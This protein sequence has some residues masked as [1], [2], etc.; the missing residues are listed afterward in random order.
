MK[1]IFWNLNNYSKD[2]D[3]CKPV[4]V[5]DAFEID[6]NQIPKR[7]KTDSFNN[8]IKLAKHL[9]SKKNLIT[10]IGFNI[11]AHRLTGSG[12]YASTSLAYF[13]ISDGTAT[14][15]LS[16]TAASF[17]A[18][19]TT[20]TKQVESVEA[21]DTVSLMQQWNCFLSS[22]DNTVSTIKKF[23]MVNASSPTNLFNNVKFT[24]ISKDTTKELYFR[25]RLTFI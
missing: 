12:T 16:D 2:G 19:G 7:I 15:A 4:G 14:P 1:Q 3:S 8:R 13:T 17:L 11:I 23:A 9:F 5:L 24:A 10:T 20:F 22:T 21:F 25:Y 18:D 6:L